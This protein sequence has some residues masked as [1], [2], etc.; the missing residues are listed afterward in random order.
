M[1]EMSQAQ[2]PKDGA[3]ATDPAGDASDLGEILGFEDQDE[4][5]RPPAEDGPEDAAP[6]DPTA[7]ANAAV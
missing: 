6:E 7:N 3:G 1:S 5:T 4:T 2:E